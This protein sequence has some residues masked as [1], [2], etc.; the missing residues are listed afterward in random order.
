MPYQWTIRDYG[1]D[2]QVKITK[3]IN[4]SGD[5]HPE[6][7]FFLVQLKCIE[8][9]NL[10]QKY[11][12]YPIP[13]KKISQ[14]YGANLPVLLTIYDMAENKF[15]FLWIDDSLISH[16][17]NN[18][19]HWITR[20]SINLKISAAN[21]INHEILPGLGEYVPSWKAPLKKIITPGLYFELK[22]KSENICQPFLGL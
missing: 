12:S 13:V 21:I 1:I 6:S 4:D 16:L 11:F 15:Y 22:S 2:G 18:N 19:P 20:E 5:L 10:S 17:D 7:K 3:Q 8:A 9:L 14:W